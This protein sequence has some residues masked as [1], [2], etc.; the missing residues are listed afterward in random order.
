MN[1]VWGIIVC[2]ILAAIALSILT[3]VNG[4]E[5]FNNIE[6]KFDVIVVGLGPSSTI[7]VSN[8]LEKRK[9]LKIAVI[10]AGTKT[11]ADIGGT[12][13]HTFPGEDIDQV[14]PYDPDYTIF[15]VPGEYANIAWNPKGVPYAQKETP[16]TYQGVG[17]GG[18]ACFNGMLWHELPEWWVTKYFPKGWEWPKIEAYANKIRTKVN[19]T[20]NPS[21]NNLGYTLGSYDFMEDALKKMNVSGPVDERMMGIHGPSYYGRPTVASERGLRAGAIQ[22]LSEFLDTSGEVK[23]IYK[24]RLTIYPLSKVQKIM[25]KGNKAKGVL[26][27]TRPTLEDLPEDAGGS[28]LPIGIQRKLGLT[29]NGRV[30]MGCGALQTPRILMLSGI[31]PSKARLGNSEIKGIF[32]DK[33]IDVENPADENGNVNFI[34]PPEFKINN[35]GIGVGLSDKVASAVIFSSRPCKEDLE[36]AVQYNAAAYA[37]NSCSLCKYRDQKIGPMSQFGPVFVWHANIDNLIE[38]PPPSIVPDDQPN[39]EMFTQQATLGSFGNPTSGK[40][41]DFALF[42]FLLE[43]ATKG[44]VRLNEYGAIEFPR[45]YLE[46]EDLSKLD[47]SLP[48]YKILAPYDVD[49]LAGATDLTSRMIPQL[50][51]SVKLKF[52]P[53]PTSSIVTGKALTVREYVL[54]SNP[55]PEGGGAP[56]SKIGINHWCNT[57]P[58][59]EKENYG[60]CPDTLLIKGTNN[61]HCID[62]SLF[63]EQPPCH[64]IAGVFILGEMCSEILLRTI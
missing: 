20:Q 5:N 60:T 64:P 48:N 1:I 7:V 16:F 12:T 63:P 34:A 6:E 13:I 38:N 43:P 32:G 46:G 55:I 35:D 30:I 59:S 25:M 57:A 19:V 18:N 49:R 28:N 11:F 51:K 21:T 31:G 27:Y 40:P 39:M 41:G 8:L 53:G 62:A 54:S 23:K 2:M 10:E 24:N 29:K 9:D 37:K 36:D 58:L 14:T 56:F 44:L 45:I 42:N 47:P 52:G 4:K 3:L 26:F 15:D 17:Y 50:N 22:Y 61:I 33:I